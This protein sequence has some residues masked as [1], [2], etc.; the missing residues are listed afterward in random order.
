MSHG[1]K[2]Q[3]H[4]NAVCILTYLP[5][6]QP[7]PTAIG[8]SWCSALL[9]RK[10]TEVHSHRSQE[11]WTDF[12]KSTKAAMVCTNLSF[13]RGSWQ[14]TKC[15]L[16]LHAKGVT[17][18]ATTRTEVTFTGRPLCSQIT[19]PASIE[20]EAAWAPYPMRTFWRTDNPTPD[21]PGHRH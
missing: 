6:P 19:C 10:D 9:G 3:R 14:C 11:T 21:C 7:I 1:K 20:L 15:T 17:V 13:V 16:R 18:H 12:G 2:K 5:W 8:T 4:W